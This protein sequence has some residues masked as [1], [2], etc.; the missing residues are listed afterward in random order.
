[1]SKSLGNVV[2]PLKIMEQSGADI[3]RLWTMTSDYAEDIRIGKDTLKNTSD[4]YRRIRNTLRFLLGALDG[5]NKAEMVEFFEDPSQLPE[6]EQLVLHQLYEMDQKIRGYIKNYEFGKLAKE[7]HEFCN[8][9]LSAFYFDIRK[10]RLYCDDPQSFERRA[11]RSVMAVI[12]NGLT[13]WLAPILS[14]TAEEAWSHRPAGVFEDVESVHL[15]DFP[16]VP[17]NWKNDELA[18]QWYRIKQVR[19][20]VTAALEPRRADKTIGSSLE[21]APIIRANDDYKK[22][23]EHK[24]LADIVIVSSVKVEKGDT[25]EVD[26][27]KA[28]GEKC[29]RCWKVLPEVVGHAD[30]ICNR[31]DDVVNKKQAA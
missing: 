29:V 18:Y 14:F 20:A 27:E 12:Y 9:T 1:M 22:A 2:D 8:N 3:L 6:L 5:F 16:E 30:H 25:L 19:E 15:R 23:L 31:C 11:C 26:F 28:D 21:A 17:A 13:A 10:D 24:D 4:L 7:L